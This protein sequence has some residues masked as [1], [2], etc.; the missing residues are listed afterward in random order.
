MPP[1]SPAAYPDQSAHGSLKGFVD[2]E[3]RA[4]TRAELVRAFSSRQLDRA[5][6]D[7]SIVRVLPSI[8]VGARHRAR[9]PARVD[10]ALLWA[11]DRA[12]LGGMSAAHA[13]GFL[14]A[15][16]PRVTLA[17]PRDARLRPPEWIVVI[18]P[19]VAWVAVTVAGA[20]SVPAL[21]ALLQSWTQLPPDRA[22]SLLL[23]AARRGRFDAGDLRQRALS[24]PRLARRRALERLLADLAR[25]PQS[26]LEHVAM[27]RVFNTY[28]FRGFTRQV[29]VRAPGRRYVL[30]MWHA[31]A[32]VAVELDG[33]LFHGDDAARRRDLAR[34]TDLA[35]MGIT[36]I[37]LT[38]EDVTGRPQWCRARVRAAIA[39]RQRRSAA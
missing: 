17:A 6:R 5:I 30:D 15:P 11:G 16:P 29:P 37:R 33:R 39:A 26:Y 38:F 9:Y 18:Q 14:E 25:G 12:A 35:S 31:D 2:A 22:M 10:A 28:D 32:R 13:H 3:P 21:D 34:D 19:S 8:Y 24:Y 7:C 27:T 1:D 36:T 4:F 20:R 23:D